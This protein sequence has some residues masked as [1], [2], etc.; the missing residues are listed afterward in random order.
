MLFPRDTVHKV[1]DK[2][3]STHTDTVALKFV[4]SGP[5]RG[6]RGQN[7]RAVAETN[8]VDKATRVNIFCSFDFDC[9]CGKNCKFVSSYNMHCIASEVETSPSHPQVISP[10]TL[11][12]IHPLSSLQ[13]PATSFRVPGRHGLTLS[14]GDG[15]G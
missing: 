3:S 13:S 15:G 12:S 1:V 10:L 5:M 2:L 7:H 9:E 14:Q 11:P 8:E 4:P 6:S